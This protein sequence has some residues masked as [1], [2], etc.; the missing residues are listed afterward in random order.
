M[1]LQALLAGFTPVPVEAD[2]QIT[3]LASDSRNVHRGDLFLAV[4]GSRHHGLEF[5]QRVKE[6]GAAAVAWEPPYEGETV[7]DI[8][9]PLIAVEELSH[10]LGHIASCFHGEPSRNL[11]VVGITGTDGKTSCAHFIAQALDQGSCGVIGTLG[12]GIYGALAAASHTTPDALTL[13]RQLAAFR[14]QGVRF[15][16]MEVSSHALQQRRVAGLRYAVAVLTNLTRDHLDYHGEVAAY[17]AAKKRLFYEHEIHHAVL[18]LDD[19]LG[20][21][22]ATSLAGRVE[23]IGYGMGQRFPEGSDAWVWGEDLESSPEGLSLRIVSSWGQG[24]LRVGLLGRFNASNLLAVLATLL[25]L[26]VPFREAL[27]RLSR[28]TILPGRMERF[29]GNPGQPLAVVD[30]AHTPH[31]LERVLQALR[32]HVRGRLWCVFGCGGDRDTGKRSLMGACAERYADRLIITNDNPRTEDPDRIIRDI[33]A[34]MQRPRAAEVL[35]KREQAIQ[36]ALSEAKAGDIVAILGKGHEDYQ[37]LGTQCIPYSDR[38]VVRQWFE[39]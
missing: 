14:A 37:L 30:Y 1:S 9:L 28:V 26:K 22:L 7:V 4:R 21:E 3:G 2:R 31:A 18:N 35:R 13:Q 24:S 25:I 34:G 5:L 32:E 8:N 12:Y 36:Y 27:Q 15:V 19:P 23:R 16:V 10:K 39:G 38:Q 17:A 6:A 11:E 33:L 20:R 29:G